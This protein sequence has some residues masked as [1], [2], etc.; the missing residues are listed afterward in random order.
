V[1]FAGKLVE[2]FDAYAVDFVVDV[3]A[4]RFVRIM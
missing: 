2:E 3:E 4:G 1:W